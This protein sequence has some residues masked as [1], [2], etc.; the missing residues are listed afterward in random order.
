MANPLLSGYCEALGK[1]VLGSFP[2]HFPLFW[3]CF[4]SKP[5]SGCL[6]AKNKCYQEVLL[7]S[8]RSHSTERLWQKIALCRLHELLRGSWIPWGSCRRGTK[9]LF[10]SN[11]I[12]LVQSCQ[13][14]MVCCSC[15]SEAS[16]FIAFLLRTRYLKDIVINDIA[17]FPPSLQAKPSWAR[18]RC[19]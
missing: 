15:F 19:C 8:A 14:T 18:T 10:L 16:R 6:V 2:A 12:I 3:A 7:Q 17:G 1:P 4:M 13:S 5:L 11:Y 9:R